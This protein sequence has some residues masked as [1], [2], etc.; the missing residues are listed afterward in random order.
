MSSVYQRW[1]QVETTL[2]RS[3]LIDRLCESC[4]VDTVA[5]IGHM[6]LFW[7]AVLEARIGGQVGDRTDRWIEEAAGWRG[8]SG[9]FAS[10]IRT[11]HL[12][13]TGVIRDWME[14]YAAIDLKR[15]RETVRK[16]E[17]RQGLRGN[18]H[19][20]VPGTLTGTVP[21]TE[22]GQSRGNS[23][24]SSSPVLSL[25]SEPTTNYL[26]P[27]NGRETADPALAQS[28]EDF[29]GEYSFGEFRSDVIGL[30]RSARRPWSIAGVLRRHLQGNG[31]PL[32]TDEE[33]G[34]AV[35]EYMADNHPG[36]KAVL[37]A[38]YLRGGERQDERERSR[39][40]AAR[41]EEHIQSEK[42]LAKAREREER[43]VQKMVQQFQ[44][45]QP[46][47]YT[48]L[49]AEAAKAVEA[50]PKVARGIMLISKLRTLIREEITSARTH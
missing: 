29:L 39:Q 7:S 3:R 15:D 44:I 40:R 31:V 28:V 23:L 14:K 46:A 34:R 24:P 12:D 33:V 25:S 38:G 37:F 35:Q 27:S 1:L 42:E 21:G 17:Y 47:R 32:R 43:E 10:F 18:G 45:E 49:Y 50:E 20:A 22:A 11:H 5:A 9:C 2:A 13:N 8:T 30:L 19:G 26:E 4:G 16:R 36:F 6:I 41:E 48:E